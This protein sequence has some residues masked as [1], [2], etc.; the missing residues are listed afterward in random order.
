MTIRAQAKRRA[1]RGGEDRAGWQ[2]AAALA[3]DVD[4]GFERFLNAYQDRVYGYALNLTANP[5][6]AEEVAQ[7]AFV[8]AYRALRTYPPA[9]RRALALRAWL[10]AIVLNRVRNLARSPAAKQLSLDLARDGRAALDVPDRAAGPAASLERNES[11]AELRGAV[12]RLPLRYRG[13]IVLRHIEERGY[14][15]IASILGQPAGTVKSNVH[16]GLALL[17]A[18]LQRRSHGIEPS[19]LA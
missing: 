6:V 3:R 12:A 7:D 18:D 16:R 13:A 17:R 2:I 5:S 11:L 8:A 19:A 1:V 4:G 9:R 10:F 15:E 14:A